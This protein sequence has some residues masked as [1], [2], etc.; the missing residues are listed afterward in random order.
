MNIIGIT[1]ITITIIGITN[2]TGIILGI[3][4]ITIRFSQLLL[5]VLLGVEG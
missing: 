4:S 2:I 1:S 3:I 5:V